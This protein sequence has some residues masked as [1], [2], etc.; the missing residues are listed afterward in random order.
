MIRHE[1]DGDSRDGGFGRGADDFIQVLFANNYDMARL[2]RGGKLGH[3][4]PTTCTGRHCWAMSSTLWTS[5]SALP[6]IGRGSLGLR[7]VGSVIL[8][9]RSPQ[10]DGADQGA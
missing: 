1:A 7:T 8:D 5:R 3:T 10:P 6:I 9:S 2:V 4:Q